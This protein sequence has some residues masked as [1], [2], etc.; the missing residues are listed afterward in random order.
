MPTPETLNIVGA[1]TI[2]IANVLIATSL[3]LANVNLSKVAGG[4]VDGILLISPILYF[5]SVILTIYNTVIGNAK[6]E[7]N[8][9][10]SIT[11]IAAYTIILGFEIS[12]IYNSSVSS[13]NADADSE[14]ESDEKED[15]ISNESNSS[16]IL[17]IVAYALYIIFCI[18]GLINY[19]ENP[20]LKESNTGK[21][22]I[23]IILF[24]CIPVFGLLIAQKTSKDQKKKN[25]LGIATSSLNIVLFLTLNVLMMLYVFSNLK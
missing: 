7:T 10:L 8:V 13:K 23:Y 5:V 1:F 6:K 9:M 22:L 2:A 24:L 20:A 3:A 4:K 12:N 15:V 14:S 11:N 21:I 19:G 16:Q 18:I 25:K 17:L